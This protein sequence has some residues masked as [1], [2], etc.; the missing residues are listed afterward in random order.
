[1]KGESDMQEQRR[2]SRSLF[3]IIFPICVVVV[4]IVGMIVWRDWAAKHKKELTSFVVPAEPIAEPIETTAES[5]PSVAR[6]EMPED[7]EALLSMA[8]EALEDEGY[9]E[10]GSVSK[11]THVCFLLEKALECNCDAQKAEELCQR[12]RERS[13]KSNYGSW[14]VSNAQFAELDEKIKA[15][16]EM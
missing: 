5:T 1:L 6:P 2:K 8:E 11:G 16:K 12:L 7:P 15:A 9:F 13:A 14:F 10:S 3:S 4:L